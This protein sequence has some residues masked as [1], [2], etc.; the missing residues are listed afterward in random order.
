MWK[1]WCSENHFVEQCLL[2]QST[3]HGMVVAV[4]D[5][6]KYLWLM[7]AVLLTTDF[8]LKLERLHATLGN[9]ALSAVYQRFHCLHRTA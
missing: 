9:A 8:V 5:E 6:D 2:G 7:W 1:L 4:E 3:V